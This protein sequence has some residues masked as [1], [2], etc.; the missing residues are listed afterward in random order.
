VH[1]QALPIFEVQSRLL[2]GLIEV[3]LAQHIADKT[4]WQ[5]LLKSDAESQDLAAYS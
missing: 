4:N 2:S 5:R 3:V 1:R